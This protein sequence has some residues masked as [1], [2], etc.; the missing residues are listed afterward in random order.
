[1]SASH[2]KEITTKGWKRPDGPQKGTNILNGPKGESEI[3]RILHL[4]S[5]IGRSQIGRCF[6]LRCV[7]LAIRPIS[8]SPFGSAFV[9]LAVIV[10][11]WVLG[12]AGVLAG[13]VTIVRA[14][15]ARKTTALLFLCANAG[16]LDFSVFVNFM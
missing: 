6:P 15:T 11:C 9:G 1:M 12:T 7:Q 2:A 16:W 10:A 4:K 13:V 8:N 5:E 14:R 3:G